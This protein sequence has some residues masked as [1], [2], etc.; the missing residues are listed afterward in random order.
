MFQKTL[1][2]PVE[3]R[4]VALHSGMNVMVRIL[5]AGVGSGI[6]MVRTDIKGTPSI[7]AS[8]N[9]V[10][11]TKRG[12]NLGSRKAKILTV[13]HLLSA[14]AGT[15]ITNAIVEIN[16][17]EPP[18]LD[19]SS[20]EYVR[21]IKKAGIRVQA[22]NV[23]TIRI[24]KPL[25]ISAERARIIALPSDRFV[26]SFMI[27][28][29][30]T[31]IGSQVHIYDS[32]AGRY[33]TDIAPARTYGFMHEVENLRKAGLIKGATKKNAIAITSKG[34]SVKLRFKDELV[35]HKILDLIGDIS[36]TGAYVYA[37]IIAMRSG[38]DLNVK[39]AKE[40]IKIGGRKK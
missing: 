18:V 35:R 38:H 26:V 19:G 1:K 23:K 11:D 5:P 17:P 7:K 13:E 24:C 6:T 28:Y 12:T 20:I 3:L 34:Y 10:I 21:A 22:A 29:P 25:M 31:F 36:L 15:G 8:I 9:N 33:G 4:G 2:R 16:G 39:L 32:M 37:H 14:F 40:L 27:N 30:G